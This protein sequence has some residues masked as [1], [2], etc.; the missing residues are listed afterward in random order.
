LGDPPK[1]IEHHDRAKFEANLMSRKE[2]RRIIVTTQPALQPDLAT[3][4]NP[5]CPKCGIAMVKRTAKQGSNMGKTFWGCNSFP[6]C[7]GVIPIE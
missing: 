1:F 6:K 4:E 5:S 2:E 7:R 3:A